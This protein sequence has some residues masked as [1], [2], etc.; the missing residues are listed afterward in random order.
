MERWNG[1]LRLCPFLYRL[2][3]FL[4]RYDRVWRGNHEAARQTGHND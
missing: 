3:R 1:S 2:C 4:N